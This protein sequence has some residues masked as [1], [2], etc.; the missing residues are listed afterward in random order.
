MES[1]VVATVQVSVDFATSCLEK[2]EF[3]WDDTSLQV[4]LSLI[5]VGIHMFY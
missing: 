4:C 2:I 3:R 1:I 5:C